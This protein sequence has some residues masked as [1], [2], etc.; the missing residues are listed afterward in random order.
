[1]L[2]IQV[3][4]YIALR[5]TL[6]YKLREL[7]AN[8]RAFARFAAAQGE[9]H[10]QASSAVHWAGEASSPRARYIWLRDI[11]HLARFLH[12]EDPA[13]EVPANPFRAPKCRRLPY[14]YSKRQGGYMAP[15]Y[16]ERP[17]EEMLALSRTGGEEW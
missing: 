2:K 14:V 7:S 8:L 1:M 5:Q 9:S 3:E 17:D 15:A 11:A 10:V 16:Y 4:R 12:A 6:G 13:H